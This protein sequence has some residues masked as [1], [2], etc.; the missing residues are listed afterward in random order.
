VAVFVSFATWGFL[1][2]GENASIFLATPSMLRRNKESNRPPDL[3]SLVHAI[4]A[5]FPPRLA[6][7]TQRK[8]DPL[9]RPFLFPSANSSARAATVI[10]GTQPAGVI[11]Q[12]QR[13]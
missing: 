6:P 1:P 8:F 7:E 4:T 5:L 13:T 11:P 2:V 3:A 10:L 12:A 9:T